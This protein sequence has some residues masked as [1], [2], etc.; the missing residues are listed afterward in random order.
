MACTLLNQ[1][2]YN[3]NKFDVEPNLFENYMLLSNYVKTVKPVIKEIINEEDI[4]EFTSE[5]T[6]EVKPIKIEKIFTPKNDDK[7]FWSIYT[8]HIGESEYYMIGN[9]CKNVEINEKKKIVDFISK[10]KNT[11]K[12][13]ANENGIKITNVKLQIIESELMVSRKTSWY[14]FWIM[15]MYY[16]INALMIQ[17]NIF[18]KFNINNDYSTYLFSRDGYSTSIDFTELDNEKYNTLTISKLQIDPFNDKILKGISTYKVCELENMMKIL[19]VSPKEEKS[20]KSDFYEC[21]IMKLVS[22]NIQTNI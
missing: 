15:C 19:D 20:K 1:I 2:F 3:A 18:M 13:T 22:M 4:N 6:S 10:N 5:I 16:K 8:L 14:T 7:L 17:E 9:N 11:I 21:I 12:S